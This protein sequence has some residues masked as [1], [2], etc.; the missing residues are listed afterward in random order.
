MS[1]TLYTLRSRRVHFY[2]WGLAATAI[3]LLFACIL[4]GDSG[5]AA[6]NVSVGILAAFIAFLLGSI[7]IIGISSRDDG[8]Y[9]INVWG[10][11]ARRPKEALLAKPGDWFVIRLVGGQVNLLLFGGRGGRLAHKLKACLLGAYIEIPVPEIDPFLRT[12]WFVLDSEDHPQ[13]SK[14]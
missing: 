3:I 5:H 12:L 1:K 14:R 8:I 6:F 7:Q 2:R 13:G 9:T 11:K 4:L 10:F